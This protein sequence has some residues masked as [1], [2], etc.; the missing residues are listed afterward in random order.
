MGNQDNTTPLVPLSF[1]IQPLKLALGPQKVEIRSIFKLC[2]E[3]STLL[4]QC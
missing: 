3:S 4:N 2:S 1:Y